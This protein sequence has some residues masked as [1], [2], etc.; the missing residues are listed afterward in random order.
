MTKTDFDAKLSSLNRKITK[1]KTYHLIVK[2]ELN[3]LKKFDSSYYN[4]KSYFE[5]DGK[6]NYLI[7]QPLSKYF[8]LI[9]NTKYISSWKSK[10][11][12]D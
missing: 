10:G 8:K 9:A 11:L 3:K 4:G 2:N 6:P 7:F 12:S 1:N 5:E